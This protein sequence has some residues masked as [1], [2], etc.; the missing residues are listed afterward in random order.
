MIDKLSLNQNQN[1]VLDRKWRDKEGMQCIDRDIESNPR[2]ETLVRRDG[3][4]DEV[5]SSGSK[6]VVNGVCGS[7]NAFCATRSCATGM[8]S[9][10]VAH[11]SA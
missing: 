3:L 6:L 8:E 4:K 10:N 7:H 2:V 11:H 9:G 1:G 5:G